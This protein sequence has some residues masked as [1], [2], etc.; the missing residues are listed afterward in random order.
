MDG[1]RAGLL[2]REGQAWVGAESSG[3]CLEWAEGWRAGAG[4]QQGQVDVEAAL[5]PLLGSPPEPSSL[6]AQP[7]HLW[8]L[9]TWEFGE[10]AAG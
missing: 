4:S 3:V 9:C 1:S 10:L 7:S 2:L 8:L 6:R 5:G